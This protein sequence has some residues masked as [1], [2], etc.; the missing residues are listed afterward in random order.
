MIRC[1]AGSMLDAVRGGRCVAFE[2]DELE[3]ALRA[4][5]SVLI[6][7]TAREVGGVG[8]DGQRWSVHAEPWAGGPCSHV[9]RVHAEE[10]TGRRLRL[11][12]SAAETVY[13]DPEP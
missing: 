1:R 10:V 11:T 7:G 9:V 8:V 13:V 3:P 4:G 5:W 2:A 6:I 12:P